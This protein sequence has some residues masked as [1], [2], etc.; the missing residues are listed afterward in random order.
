MKCFLFKQ[1][2][3]AYVLALL[4]PLGVSA[5]SLLTGTPI[6][7]PSVDYDTGLPSTTVNGPANAFDNNSS[8]CYASYER[9]YTWV[10]LDLGKKHVISKIFYRP[11]QGQG[12]RLELG[13]FE[14]ANLP[15]F[16]D[17]I[18]LYTIP[19]PVPDN[20]LSYC[21]V[22]CSRGFRYV[23]YVGPNDKRCKIAI[24]KFYGTPSEGDDSQL[25]VPG[26]LPVVTI[27]T[28]NAVEINNSN[29][30]V[31][32]KGIMSLIWNDGKSIYTDSLQIR[33]RG[34]GSWTFPQKPYKMTLN[35]K[36]RML[37]FPAKAKD[38]TLINT[39]RDKS[40]MR[41][42]VAFEGSR[43]LQMPYTPA[44]T[45]VDVY[46]NGEYKGIYQLTD[47]VEVHKN[48]VE[49]EELTPE[50]KTQPTISGGYMI[51]VDSYAPQERSMFYSSRFKT[52]ITVKYPNERKITT[53]QKQ[54]LVNYYN[55]METR[56]FF[57]NYTD[58]V[59]GYESVIDVNTYLRRFIAMEL[60]ANTDSYHSVHMYKKRND[61]H[62]YVGPVWD[63]DLAFDN[64]TRAYP[65][66]SSSDFVVFNSRCSNVPGMKETLRRILAVTGDKMSAYWSEA[67]NRRDLTPEHFDRYIDSIALACDASQK[68]HYTRW[69]T[70]DKVIVLTPAARGSYQAEVD[71]L[72]QYVRARI[73]WM[74][75]KIGLIPDGVAEPSL[76]S[77]GT[78]DGR[79]TTIEVDGF[80]Q[81]SDIRIFQLDGTLV[82][83]RAASGLTND[84]RLQP[85]FYI[86]KVIEPSGNAVQK[87]LLLQ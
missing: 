14:G 8:T 70:L 29:K 73:A 61:L 9:S 75:R 37:G 67:R 48:R 59:L 56:T 62:F 4:F 28:E 32:Q 25:Y 6:G 19:E 83:R 38:W 77:I 42:L 33:G 20:R 53:V 85:G 63:C 2:L 69:K 64:D 41:N 5:Q 11:C 44:S 7:S 68:L 1:Y 35:H 22:K 58:P 57:A 31:N 24:I 71:F 23:R 39:Y 34:N 79:G 46:Y 17:A 40:L 43:L 50:D 27:H 54:A 72:K 45:L 3:C 87:K 86:V 12:D 18:P 51:E 84:F 26:S 13:V 15:D 36:Y 16:S 55:M 76:R 21:S 47:Q 80:E 10:G 78:I 74:D 30:T 65:T 49:V 60:A 52:P 66:N 82:E 81:G